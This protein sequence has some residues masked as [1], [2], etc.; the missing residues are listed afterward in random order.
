MA[1]ASKPLVQG[2]TEHLTRLLRDDFNVTAAGD[3]F[4]VQSKDFR[5]VGDY[6]GAMLGRPEYHCFVRA[7]N[8]AGGT[9]GGNGNLTPQ[10]SPANPPS[11]EQP[12]TFSDAVIALSK[13]QAATTKNPQLDRTV[14]FGL[15][16]LGPQTKTG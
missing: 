7:N 6:I 8:P 14:P 5:S 1:L 9:G 4:V 13:A 10:T 11:T 12:Q 15:R 2:G 3:S 16:G